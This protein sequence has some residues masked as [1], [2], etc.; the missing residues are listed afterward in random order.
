MCSK[1]LCRQ[2]AYTVN[3]MVPQTCVKQVPYTI[4]RMV[5]ET[6]YRQVPCTVTRMVRETN[7][8][9]VPV[10]TCRMVTTQHVKQVP[11]MTRRMKS[12]QTRVCQVPGDHLPDGPRRTCVKKVRRDR[13]RDRLRASGTRCAF[14]RPIC[15]MQT[16]QCVRQECFTGLQGR[17]HMVTTTVCEPVTVTRQV[18]EF[19]MVCT[20]R[21]RS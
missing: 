16:E 4:T 1:T 3:Q 15:E 6:A 13:L 10:T 7:V 17:S 5:K 19:K 12:P 8:K 11:V 21:G 18:T 20:S 2:E 14:P 9:R